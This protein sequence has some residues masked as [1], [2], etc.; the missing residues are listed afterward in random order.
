MGDF[1][2]QIQCEEVYF[3][4]Y[5]IEYDLQGYPECDNIVPVDSDVWEDIPY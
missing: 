1:E 3:I 2:C 5:E 4:R